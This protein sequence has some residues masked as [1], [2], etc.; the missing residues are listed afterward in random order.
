MKA[1]QIIKI[2]GGAGLIGLGVVMIVTNPGKHAYEKYST[3]TLTSYL[4]Q[5]VCSQ[6]SGVLG[7]F[8]SD[9]CKTLVD[10]GKTNIHKVI[11]NKTVR[12][13][14]L[15]FSI[16]ETELLL[17]PPISNYEFETIGIFQK[18]YTYQADKF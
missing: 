5:E 11:S 17:P 13:N 8:L 10:I 18:F 14:Y 7:G 2:A 9:H 12:Q 6:S 3:K 4:K 1:L 16:Y 15:L